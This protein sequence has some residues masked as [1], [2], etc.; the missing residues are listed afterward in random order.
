MGSTACTTPAPRRWAARASRPPSWSRAAGRSSGCVRSCSARCCSSP[1]RSS[2]R[3]RRT[4]S[5][6]AGRTRD[7]SAGHRPGRG[8]HRR[9][10]DGRRA[11]AGAPG[12]RR[13]LP[14]A[15]AGDPLL[16]LRRARRRSLAARRRHGRRPR[17]GAAGAREDPR[18][19][20]R[21]SRRV[22]IALAIPAVALLAGL[23]VYAVTQLPAPDAPPQRSARLSTSV[24]VHERHVT[25]TVAGVTFDLRGLD[26]LG[27]EL[28]LFVAAL[29]AAVLLRAQRS[30][31]EEEDEE[32]E[33]PP[34]MPGPVR[35]L[36]FAL[37]GPLLVFGAYIVSHGHLTPGG[38]FQGG[39]I[40]AAALLLAYLANQVLPG[41]A[42]HTVGALEVTHALGAAAFA[43]VAVGGLVFAGAA[44]ANFIALGVSGHLLSGG[45]ILVLQVAVGV[46]VAS[47]VTLI[48]TEMLDQTMLAGS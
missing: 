6:A 17:D 39:V 48:L 38:G 47:A 35:A 25:D 31:H 26:T 13:R 30:E 7:R 2:R 10:R 12:D 24:A 4:R 5:T 16:R 32:G 40:L 29:G 8:R 34:A 9:H 11:R 20:R 28:I 27:E 45:T 46:E 22:R 33:R 18:R 42:A 15:G 1:R 19:R 37:V 41:E 14:G 44:L 3:R 23:L 21:M 36:G 43:L